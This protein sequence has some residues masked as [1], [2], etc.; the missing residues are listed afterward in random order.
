MINKD[1][2]KEVLVED[3][4]TVSIVIDGVDKVYDF[5]KDL[6]KE[7]Q[8][9]FYAEITAINILRAHMELCDDPKF[10]DGAKYI[11]E[12]FEDYATNC[13]FGDSK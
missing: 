5:G 1:K 6:D 8:E 7:R 10:D 3:T 13:G 9:V 2:S 11:I 4:N 12:A